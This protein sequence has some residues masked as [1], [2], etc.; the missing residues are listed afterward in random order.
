MSYYREKKLVSKEISTIMERKQNFNINALQI[1][2]GKRY[3][4]SD[5]FITKLLER[6]EKNSEDILI[7]NDEVKFI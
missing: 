4:I 6:Y 3:E 1:E 2:L 5:R 7:E